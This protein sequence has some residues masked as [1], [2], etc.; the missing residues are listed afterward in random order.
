M[1]V[2]G[3]VLEIIKQIEE[4][5]YEAYIAG[6]TVFMHILGRPIKEYDVITSAPLF[7]FGK[8]EKREGNTL[9]ILNEEK[10]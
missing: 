2:D 10:P 3:Y 8:K 9:H 4:K 1:N 7:S 5:G 6:T